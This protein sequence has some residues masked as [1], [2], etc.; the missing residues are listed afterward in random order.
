[1]TKREFDK[2]LEAAGFRRES[3]VVGGTR[4][5]RR[6]GSRT[7]YVA[8]SVVHDSSFRLF[9]ATGDVPAMWPADEIN[10]PGGLIEAESPWFSYSREPELSD[11]A[12]LDTPDR[13]LAKLS[14]WFATVGVRWLAN[15]DGKTDGEWREEHNLLV[16]RGGRVTA[17]PKPGRLPP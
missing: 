9:L 12:Q 6:V 13:A 1:M 7:Q 10:P 4:F 11:D 17:R 8:K 16:R 5:V 14:E 15:P 2:A 3:S